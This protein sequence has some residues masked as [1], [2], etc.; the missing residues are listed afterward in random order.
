MIFVFGD[1]EIDVARRELRR[2][3]SPC[4]VEPQVFDLLVHLIT[5]RDRVVDKA[6]LLDAV[7]GGRAVS[8]STLTSRIS[9][10]RRA[11][12]DSG[13]QQRW[14]RTVARRG[15]RFHGEVF[16]RALTP[17]AR[18]TGIRVA[19]TERNPSE[20]GVGATAR[21]STAQPGIAVLPFANLS[22]DA[23]QSTSSMASSRISSPGYGS[24]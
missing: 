2:G 8:E 22:S 18:A 5:H 20:Q 7:W 23:A 15:F 4:H 19:L 3:G 11:I 1:C 10:A 16:E 17:P 21:A 6:E 12:G 14:L 9:A 24:A 13:D